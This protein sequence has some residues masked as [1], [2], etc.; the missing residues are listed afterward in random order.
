VQECDVDIQTNL[1][2]NV[3]VTGSSSLMQG[4]VERLTND[5]QNSSSP[6]CGRP[7]ARLEHRSHSRIGAFTITVYVCLQ[8]VKMRLLAGSPIERKYSSWIGGSILGCLGSFQQ[9]W[10]SKQEYEESGKVC[11]V[12]MVGKCRTHSALSQWIGRVCADA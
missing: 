8:N 6:V 9:M 1:L 11:T 10:V 2:S 3:V 4:F 5:L 7:L 12:C